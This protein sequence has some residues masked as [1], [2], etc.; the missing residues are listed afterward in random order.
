MNIRHI[1]VATDFSEASE[2]ALIAAR[3]YARAFEARV[4]VA[5]VF[6][7][8]PLSPAVSYPTQI[9]TGAN[10]GAQIEQETR[11]LLDEARTKW[12]VDVDVEALPI[13]HT[14]AST[15]LCDAADDREADL[16]IVGTHGRT[17]MTRLLLGSVA[18]QVVRHAHVPVLAMRKTEGLEE[19][20][21][22][23]LVTTDFSPSS[24]PAL[25]DAAAIARR[26][27]AHVTLAH[28]YEAVSGIAAGIPAYRSFDEVDP[29]LQSALQTLARQ[30]LG[31]G[32]GID[33][34]VGVSPAD[35]LL[36]RIEEGHYDLV[37][38]ATHGRTGLSRLLIGSVAERITRHA[39]C[40][41]W[42]SRR[43]KS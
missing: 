17:G 29:E 8:M 19:Q 4:T 7:P 21:K 38:I 27:G 25:D 40:A 3:R 42:T 41:V 2:A 14:S 35:V 24:E 1:L 30:R 33:L 43:R 36:E 39:P 6:D 10:F 28:V 26:F 37:V 16:I 34:S 5:N 31:E 18:E 12:F 11:K 9:W 22:R 13:R 20:P 15:A 32:A 23:I